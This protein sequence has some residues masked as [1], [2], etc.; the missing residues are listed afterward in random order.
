MSRKEKNDLEFGLKMKNNE[1]EK[2]II[3]IKSRMEE[4]E[5]QKQIL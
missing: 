2:D 3:Q 4:L 1:M 5:K